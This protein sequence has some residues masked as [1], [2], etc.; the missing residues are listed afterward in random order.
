VT[1][2]ATLATLR[3]QPES[4]LPVTAPNRGHRQLSGHWTQRGAAGVT[5]NGYFAANAVI[6]SCLIA[7]QS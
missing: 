7:A 6:A 2:L 1:W 3:R 4:K 5:V